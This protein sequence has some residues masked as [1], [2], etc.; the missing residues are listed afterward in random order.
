MNEHEHRFW[1][2]EG[3]TA[4]QVI[5]EGEA[6]HRQHAEH[7]KGLFERYGPTG[8]TP[9]FKVMYT[10]EQLSALYFEEP[11]PDRAGWTPLQGRYWKPKRNTKAGR[12]AAADMASVPPASCEWYGKRLLGHRYLF[13]QIGGRTYQVTAGLR[14]MEIDGQRRVLIKAAKSHEWKPV[15]GLREIKASQYHALIE[16]EQEVA[17]TREAAAAA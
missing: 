2:V 5:D 15:D 12:A 13:V 11:P 16:Q 10:G 9:P 3:G 8:A 14:W 6:L 1:I 4:Q 7:I 17:E